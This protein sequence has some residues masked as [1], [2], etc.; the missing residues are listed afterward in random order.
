MRTSKAIPR[1]GAPPDAARLYWALQELLR[2]Y[3]FRDKDRICCHGITITECYALEVLAQHGPMMLNELARRLYSDKSTISRV[4]S[5]LEQK[6]HVS[7]SADLRD[8]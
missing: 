2:V 8:G 3:Q 7:R 6:G 1:R 5:S 4:V